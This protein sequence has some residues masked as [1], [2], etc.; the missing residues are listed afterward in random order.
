MIKKLLLSPTKV[1][2]GNSHDLYEKDKAV[3]A[4]I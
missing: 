2:P 4:L 3:Y 1:E